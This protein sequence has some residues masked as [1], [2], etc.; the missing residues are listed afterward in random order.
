MTFRSHS[1][2]FGAAFTGVLALLL[3]AGCGSSSDS[4]A[5]E[6]RPTNTLRLL[7]VAPD[8]PALATTSVSF[9]ALRGKNAGIDLWYHAR[10]GRRDSTKFL[11]FRM[12]GA[13]L[14]RR[15]DG[16]VIADG[17]SIRITVTVS[18]ATNLVVDFQPSGL[19]FSTKDPARLKMFF[20]ECGDDLDRNGRVDGN[21]DAIQQQLG[22]WRQETPSDPWIRLS[23][24]VV[25]GTKEIDADL[26]GFTGY[27]VAY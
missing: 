9:Y 6:Q 3:V 24:V 14:D 1:A 17:D 15:P 20:A 8:A 25:K 21:D 22:I 5:P 11:E 27:A 26:G 12:G 19:R 2:T 4:T 16:T 10:P 18:N 13:T 7:S 23:S